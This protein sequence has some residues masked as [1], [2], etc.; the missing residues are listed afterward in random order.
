VS[1]E[2]NPSYVY[3]YIDTFFVTLDIIHN[4]GCVEPVTK[5]VELIDPVLIA[6]FRYGFTD[7][8]E[9]FV[10]ISF[11]DQSQN[12]LNNT[13]N[14]D[15]TFSTGETSTEQNPVITVTESQILTATLVIT[16]ALN[17]TD[18]VT[19]DIPIEL[20]EIFLEDTIILCYGDTMEL[21]PMGNTNYQYVW[22]PSTG[23][24]DSTA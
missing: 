8:S 21:N 10:T 1:F 2:D 22:S 18:S 24:S 23:L 11:N 4:V 13:T 6:D 19:Y 20:T 7:C 9:G 14:W 12:F 17:C 5:P 16:T 3:P 15:W